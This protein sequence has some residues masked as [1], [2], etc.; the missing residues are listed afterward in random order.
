M[1]D[2]EVK[3]SGSESYPT[4]Q[5]DSGVNS[6]GHSGSSPAEEVKDAT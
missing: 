4:E 5:Q 1:A 3:E 6:A 2:E